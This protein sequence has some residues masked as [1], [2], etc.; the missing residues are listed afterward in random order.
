[1]IFEVEERLKTGVKQR[2]ENSEDYEKSLFQ[3]HV[4]DFF[5]RRNDDVFAETEICQ[6]EDVQRDGSVA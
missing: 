6:N 2:D 1:M 3:S 5:L 4:F